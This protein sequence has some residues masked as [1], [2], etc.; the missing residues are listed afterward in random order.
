MF[1]EIYLQSV[2]R[3]TTIHDLFIYFILNFFLTDPRSPT[4]HHRSSMLD[5]DFPVS[6]T[7]FFFLLST[8]VITSRSK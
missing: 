5:P 6:F 2:A 8:E 1:C 3:I 7:H 4:P